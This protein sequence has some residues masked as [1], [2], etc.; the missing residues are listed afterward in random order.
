MK[1]DGIR[2][3]V[4]VAED[5]RDWPDHEHIVVLGKGWITGPDPRSDP[6]YYLGDGVFD[7]LDAEYAADMAEPDDPEQ[8]AKDDL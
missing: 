1:L 8:R 7:A 3:A 4:S 6:D 2:G 5:K